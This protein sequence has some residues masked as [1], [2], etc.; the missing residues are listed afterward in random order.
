M[1]TK[2]KIIKEALTLFSLKGFKA[3]SVRDISNAVG[4]KASSL[5][6]HFENKQ[7]IFETIIYRG[8]QRV[9]TFLSKFDILSSMQQSQLTNFFEISDD[10][11]FNIHFEI[12]KFYLNDNFIIKF[13]RILEMERF[14]NPEITRLYNKIFIDDILNYVSKGFSLLMELK[15]IIK[16]DPHT[17]ALKF[18]SPFF[19]LFCKYEKLNDEE[20][21]LLKSHIIEFRH[22]YEFK[23]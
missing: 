5:Y 1:N 12:F 13:R 7:D 6:N 21:S 22:T 4:I 18:Y 8:S 3:V 23:G 2:E 16:N 15:I 20:L 10:D 14:N 17:L 19:L 11:F 9:S